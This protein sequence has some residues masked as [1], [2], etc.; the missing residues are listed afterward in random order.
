LELIKMVVV[1]LKNN[2]S[3]LIIITGTEWQTQIAREHHLG[4]IIREFQGC[5]YAHHTSEFTK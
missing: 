3:V 5:Y 2:A 1:C 4:D